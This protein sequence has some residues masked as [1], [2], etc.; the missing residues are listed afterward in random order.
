MWMIVQFF[1][2]TKQ[3]F[4]HNTTLVLN[5][6]RERDTQCL[7]IRFRFPPQLQIF[8]PPPNPGFLNKKAILNLTVSQTKKQLRTFLGMVGFCQSWIP[9]FWLTVV[10]LAVAYFSKQD[11]GNV[12]A[13]LPM[14]N[15]GN[16]L[17]NWGSH[18]AD[19][20]PTLEVQTLHQVQI[21]LWHKNTTG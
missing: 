20:R 11:C 5:F 3:N 8:K 19:T 13:E 9:Q 1:S 12:M 18:W 15:S 16:C 17:V 4:D 6:L 2:P 10:S 14:G 7:P 21:V